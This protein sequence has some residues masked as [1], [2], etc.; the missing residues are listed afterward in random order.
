MTIQKQGSDRTSRQMSE[1]PEGA[2]FVW[3]TGDVFYPRKL[4]AHIGRTD[5][6]IKPRSWLSGNGWRG[7]ERMV[8]ID[9]HL[10]DLHKTHHEIEAVIGIRIR[11]DRLKMRDQIKK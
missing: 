1:A 6:I 9:H 8:V 2:F 5:I 7:L 4:A 11:N 3:C 10:M